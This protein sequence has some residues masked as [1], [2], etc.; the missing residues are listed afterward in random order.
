MVEWGEVGVIREIGG[1][2]F[3]YFLFFKW[4]GWFFGLC[5]GI[6]E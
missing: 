6:I 4:V 2:F 3:L 5:L 1:L